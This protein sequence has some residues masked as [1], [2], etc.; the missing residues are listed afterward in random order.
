MISYNSTFIDNILLLLV[1][2]LCLFLLLLSYYD[3]HYH[4]LASGL[5]GLGNALGNQYLKTVKDLWE[6]NTWLIGLHLL[7]RVSPFLLLRSLTTLWY[8]SRRMLLSTSIPGTNA[9]D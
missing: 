2:L 6:V 7:I 9:N 3:D 1:P 5:L 8:P 4:S